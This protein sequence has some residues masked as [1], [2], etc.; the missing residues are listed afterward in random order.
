MSVVC[1]GLVI[2][3]LGLTWLNFH[4]A[5]RFQRMIMREPPR[6]DQHLLPPAVVVLAMRGADPFLPDCLSGLMNQ[7]YPDYDVKIIID[8]KADPATPV[9]EEFFAAHPASNVE[10]LYLK[11]PASTCSLKVS[12]LM[13]VISQLEERY[14]VVTVL[15]ADVI[16]EPMWLR[17]LVIPL[18]NNPDLAATTGIR[19][20]M[21]DERDLGN[22]VRR[23]W[24][25]GAIIQMFLF[26]IPWGGSLAIRRSLFEEADIL[27]HWSNCLCEDTPL[28]TVLQQANRKLETVPEALMVNRESTSLAGAVRFI[29]RQLLFAQLYHPRWKWVMLPG[30]LN[31]SVPLIGC[32]VFAVA[33]S[34]QVIWAWLLPG[35]IL[36][37]SASVLFQATLTGQ[38]IKQL[39]VSKG[40]SVRD[41]VFDRKTFLAAL[42]AVFTHLWGVVRPMFVREIDWRGITYRR[43]RGKQFV[44]VEYEVYREEEEGELAESS[45]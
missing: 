4:W 2:L 18:A 26:Q 11:D 27:E 22:M 36:I 44:L 8:S 1:V 13:Q 40:V 20:F 45:I 17:S 19:W 30:I 34:Q 10:V 28:A 12:A 33:L 37:Q 35:A 21:P 23:H 24:N 25:I 43:V 16:T 3:L 38:K 29:G 31:A 15:D 9:V 42:I 6:T 32:I 7:D 14:E 39:L 5:A 41:S